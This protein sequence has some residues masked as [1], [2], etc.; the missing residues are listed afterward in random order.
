MLSQAV[1]DY[2]KAIYKLHEG[3]PVS[4]TEIA[5]ALQVSSASVT[6]MVKKLAQNGFVTH[7]SYRGVQLTSAG[8]KI[9]LEIIRHHRLLETYLRE[10]M[11][12]DWEQMHAEAERLEHHISEEFEAKLDEMLGFPT[13]DPHGDPIPALDGTISEPGGDP[14]GTFDEGAVVRILR[15]P[16]ED[17]S[18]LH[19]LEDQALLPG[20]EIRVLGQAEGESNLRIQVEDREV[21][22]TLETAKKIFGEL[23]SPSES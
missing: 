11:G 12:Y 18:L 1:E 17:P 20:S 3:A 14:I 13:R 10:I 15:V 2:L 9:A 21:A 5:R 8:E 16:D 7:E 4:T 22:I 6:N 19:R 23:V